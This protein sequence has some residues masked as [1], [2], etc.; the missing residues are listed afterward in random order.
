MVLQLAGL[1]GIVV[2]LMEHVGLVDS[3]TS[4]W[5]LLGVH[6]TWILCASLPLLL[7]P[8]RRKQ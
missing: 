8:M 7:K 2:M 3:Y 6:W 1:A 4:A 5:A